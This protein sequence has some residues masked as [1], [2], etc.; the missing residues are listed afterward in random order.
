MSGSLRLRLSL[1]LMATSDRRSFESVS[2]RAQDASRTRLH[3]AGAGGRIDGFLQTQ[4][5]AGNWRE[6]KRNNRQTASRRDSQFTAA[7][8]PA[9]LP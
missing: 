4:H 9:L 6:P 7:P 2:R 1:L 5:T 3:E 8:V